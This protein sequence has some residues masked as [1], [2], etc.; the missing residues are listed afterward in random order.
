MGGLTDIYSRH[1]REISDVLKELTGVGIKSDKNPNLIHPITESGLMEV[2]IPAFERRMRL[3]EEMEENP[4]I[5]PK[6]VSTGEMDESKKRKAFLH[7]QI[8]NFYE[9]GISMY[10]PTL[11]GII[12]NENDGLKKHKQMFAD[13]T[14]NI[15]RLWQTQNGDELMLRN[16]LGLNYHNWNVSQVPLAIDQVLAVGQAWYL[17]EEIITKLGESGSKDYAIALETL[18]QNSGI[19]LTKKGAIARASFL[20][21]TKKTKK[22]L[23]YKCNL[24]LRDVLK[25]ELDEMKILKELYCIDPKSEEFKK[26]VSNSSGSLKQRNELWNTRWL[27]RSFIYCGI[28]SR[29]GYQFSRDLAEVGVPYVEVIKDMPKQLE[30]ID[31]QSYIKKN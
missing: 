13:M 9:H 27:L 12:I 16:D 30:G 29:I 28:A 2:I 3:M 31:K 18:K 24:T 14:W 23:G 4:Q 5:F 6:K 20:L 19:N 11:P 15:V 1:T 21:K 25:K 22:L 7:E 17:S 8:Q 26:I 10:D